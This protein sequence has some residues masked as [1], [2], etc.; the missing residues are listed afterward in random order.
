[1]KKVLSIALAVAFIF[2]AM[3]ISVFA[4]KQGIVG[5]VTGG[6]PGTNSVGSNAHLGNYKDGLT[7]EQFN[8]GMSGT[9]EITINF[10]KG[11]TGTGTS[12]GGTNSV[13]EHR[14]AVD[15]EYNNLVINMVEILDRADGTD[16]T[17][18]YKYVWDVNTHAYVMIDNAGNVLED[19]P[20]N[21][22]EPVDYAEGYTMD[23][24][25]VINHSDLAIKYTD[26]LSFVD[27]KDYA[28]TLTSSI[29]PVVGGVVTEGTVNV[30]KA[31]VGAAT[32][33]PSSTTYNTI[34]ATPKTNKTW[35]DV[36]NAW[37]A[38][39]AEGNCVIGTLTITIT[40]VA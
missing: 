2:A 8:H 13:I 17:V 16:D 25:R 28:V 26:A 20:A 9:H 31:A 1:M 11:S 21:N 36:V 39:N 6:G 40:P 12:D 29:D 15:V 33:S 23:A 5:T 27:D 18:A 3:S 24:Y 34:T 30:T 10:D 4:A 22:S 7:E 35:L 14:Y 37:G 32:C 38:N 19:D